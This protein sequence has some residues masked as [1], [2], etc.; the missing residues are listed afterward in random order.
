MRDISHFD[1]QNEKLFDEKGLLTM[2]KSYELNIDDLKAKC[3]SDHYTQ[4]DQD[5]EFEILKRHV[6][7]KSHTLNFTKLYK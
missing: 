7:K 5:L 1:P 4:L 6:D 3:R 2:A